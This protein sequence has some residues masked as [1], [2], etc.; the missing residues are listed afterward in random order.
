MRLIIPPFSGG[1]SSFENDHNAGV[2]RLNPVLE[3]DQLNLKLE[4]LSLVLIF[5]D[6]RLAVDAG[7]LN[8]VIQHKFLFL[9]VL[10]FLVHRCFLAP[11]IGPSVLEADLDLWIEARPVLIYL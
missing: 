3:L 4:H 5:A 2:G 9:F 11:R 8:V 1:I 10:G 7:L 6:L